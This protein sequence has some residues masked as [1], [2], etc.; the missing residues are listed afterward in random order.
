VVAIFGPE[1]EG[2]SEH[3][4]ALSCGDAALLL[5]PVRSLAGVFAWTTSVLALQRFQRTLQALA[6]PNDFPIP[7]E[8]TD[9]STAWVAGED[10]IAGDSLVLEEFSFNPDKSHAQKV[11]DIGTW[12]AA[13]ALL[14][15]SDYA[16]WRTALP[17]KLCILP[18][19]A[20]RDFVTYGTEIQTHIRLD[21]QKKTVLSGALWTTESLPADCLL[22]APLLA[23][24]SR[25]EKTPL[26]AAQ[27]LEKMRRFD[28]QRTQL[29]GDE[30][31]AQGIVSLR[32][33]HGGER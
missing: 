5:F 16:Y 28:R 11:Q 29:G 32:F 3:A 20:F 15:S 7:P 4:G 21:P 14:D 25:T 26:T 13:H 31:T 10:L 33:F 18:E 1:T 24:D 2:A 17:K 8:P 27:V 6:L 23:T 12:I 22:Y 9:E 19:N 30:T